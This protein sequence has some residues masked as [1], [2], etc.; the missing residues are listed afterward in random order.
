[1]SIVPVTYDPAVDPAVL[2][3]Q[4]KN[5]LT[6]LEDPDAAVK[7]SKYMK[8]LKF[9]PEI[10]RSEEAKHEIYWGEIFTY[11][12]IAE[13]LD[14]YHGAQGRRTDLTFWQ[15]TRKSMTELGINDYKALERWRRLR[16]GFDWEELE[17]LKEKIRLPGLN[18]ILNRIPQ[19]TILVVPLPE[20]R[21]STL[22][23]SSPAGNWRTCLKATMERKGNGRI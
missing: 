16:D 10:Q 12:K 17:A 8:V 2:G 6:K 20:R 22:P 19:E 11:W 23:R 15:D 18:T 3:K 5:H 13:L 4:I 7:F 1:M 9:H 14:E 21:R